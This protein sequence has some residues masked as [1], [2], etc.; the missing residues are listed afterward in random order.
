MF[1]EVTR[2]G[3]RN[4]LKFCKPT[5]ET[6]DVNGTL[7]SPTSSPSSSSYRGI[8]S[9]CSSDEKVRLFKSCT[10]SNRQKVI[11]HK[12]SKIVLIDCWNT[13]T[14]DVEKIQKD[15]PTVQI[16]Q[17]KSNKPC[18][19]GLILQ[20]R[21]SRQQQQ[22]QQQTATQTPVI[23]QNVPQQT[24]TLVSSTSTPAPTSTQV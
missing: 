16:I 20:R 5:F 22:Q 23:V 1:G 10:S 17:K 11:D 24:I 6:T 19:E 18:F 8:D 14:E 3:V 15:Y 9:Y 4:I 12:L 13:I 21:L 7:N 2:I